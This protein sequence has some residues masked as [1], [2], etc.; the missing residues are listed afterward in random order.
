[1]QYYVRAVYSRLKGLIM[2]TETIE[3]TVP[4]WAI[5]AI[6]YGDLSGLST[7]DIT[8][9]DLFMDD[10]PRRIVGIEYSEEPEFKTSN[11]I[12][13]LGA[14]CVKATVTYQES[15]SSGFT[16]NRMRT[17]QYDHTKRQG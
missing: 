13:S 6:E 16:T 11:D 12:C 9:L 1:M 14:D 17:C 7:E 10:L 2:I 5:C 4:V 8:K 15:C 3:Y